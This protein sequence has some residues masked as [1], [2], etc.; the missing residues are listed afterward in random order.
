VP[1]TPGAP[2]GTYALSGF[3]NINYY[4]GHLNVSLPLLEL[5]GRGDVRF[6]MMA[7][8]DAP[9]WTIE[10]ATRVQ[11]RN[12]S[13]AFEYQHSTS[14]A[15]EKWQTYQAGYGPG[16]LVVKKVGENERVCGDSPSQ[17]HTTFSYLVFLQPDGS[18]LSLYDKLSGGKPKVFSCDPR[19]LPQMW[20]R[21]TEF[22]SRD[23][24][25]A[26]CIATA[27]IFDQ[28]DPN[29]YPAASESISV[30]GALYFADGTQYTI[31]NGLVQSIRDRN[32]NLI[33]FQYQPGTTLVSQ[34][35]DAA[36]R[37]VTVAYNTRVTAT[38]TDDTITFPGA[39]GQSRTIVVT[40]MLPRN[41]LRPDLT[42][43]SSLFPELGA[44]ILGPGPR[45][46]RI[47]LPDNRTYEFFYTP[48]GEV[49][50]VV[51]PT[52]GAI[53][54]D[55]GPGLAGAG[56]IPGVYASGQVLDS[57]PPLWTFMIESVPPPPW[58]PYV[59][60]RLL[61][62]R[63]YPDGLGM[64]AGQVTTFSRLET[65]T[66]SFTDPVSGKIRGVSLSTL[67]YAAVSRS[68]P[69][70]STPVT[71]QHYYHG[72]ARNKPVLS[73][74]PVGPAGGLAYPSPRYQPDPFEGKEYRTETAGLQRIER[75]YVEGA[76]GAGLLCQENTTWLSNN[77][78]SAR[79]MQYE[80]Q[81]AN[82]IN[83][84]E[85]NFGSA[86]AIQTATDGALTWLACPSSPPA[87]STRRQRKDY[88]LTIAYTAAPIHL[89]R[90]ITREQVLTPQGSVVADT[91]TTYA[92][93]LTDRCDD[94]SAA[95]SG[96]WDFPCHAGQSALRQPMAQFLARL[97]DCGD[98]L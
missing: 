38:E 87:N 83:I 51:L 89:R 39:H 74:P 80:S 68:G 67:A 85:Y 65:A 1:L 61:E 48:Y 32:G 95:R 33:T 71:E 44:P 5:G 70:L 90:L 21:G 63:E 3:E 92:G 57:L 55:H 56:S 43:P 79:Y 16:I 37:I 69:G 40:K 28:H 77:Q 72:E 82:L 93:I 31:T 41:R 14:A 98:E 24:S 10:T 75:V 64:P 60:R 52:G 2:A 94:H 35:Q 19:Y 6:R 23:G 62:R 86:P 73:N 11:D 18:E 45:I 30:S 81:F 84:Y 36:G 7:A 76:N 96:L 20:N 34:I 4:T 15:V 66:G 13:G 91:K 29:Q 42:Q 25:A 8:I 22:S 58:Q 50:R 27:D 26:T 12:G 97:G 17:Y 47:R 59:Y 46:V 49:A 54:Y 78:T 9:K 53:D 88:L